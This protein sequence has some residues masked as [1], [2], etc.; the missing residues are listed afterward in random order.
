MKNPGYV[1]ALGYDALTALYDP[2]V[3]LTTRERRFKTALIARGSRPANASSI[4]PAAIGFDQGLS[5]ELPYPDQTFDRVLSSLMGRLPQVL[6]SAGF[7]DVAVKGELST[8][9]GTMA[10]YQAGRTAMGSDRRQ[11]SGAEPG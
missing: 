1:P 11:S 6:R 5:Y 3:A 7:G 2:V 4:W 8:V 9:F 10:L